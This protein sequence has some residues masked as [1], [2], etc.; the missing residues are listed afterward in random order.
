M[1]RFETKPLHMFVSGVGGTEKSFL[2]KTICALVS[3]ILDDLKTQC[4]V[5]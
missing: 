5:Q 3:N 2:I 4:C 1:S